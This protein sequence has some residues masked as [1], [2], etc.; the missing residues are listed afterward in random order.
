MS[1]VD[2][3]SDKFDQHSTTPSKP[4]FTMKGKNERELLEWLKNEVVIR[5]G[6]HA[7]FFRE[8]FK[9]LRAYKGS[10]HQKPGRQTDSNDTAPLNRF[11][12]KYWVNHVYELTENMVS[13]MTRVKPAVD[14]L[15]SNDEYADKVSAKC[16]DLL[17]RHLQY[18]NNTDLLLQKAHRH[19]LIF[20]ETYIATT[21]NPE[22]GDLHPEYVKMRD[23]A[24]L[25]VLK[26]KFNRN[27][28]VRIGDVSTK[29][30][31]PW[32]V[33]LECKG[34]YDKVKSV[35]VKELVHIE[36]LKRQYPSLQFQ[37]D[38]NATFFDINLL[39]DAPCGELTWQYTFYHVADNDFPEGVCIKFTANDVL[40]KDMLGFSHG[41]FPLL[42]LTDIDIP[43]RLHGMSRYQQV[44]VLQNAH[45]NLSQSIIK[46][47][48]LL[49]APKWMM[50][51]GTCKVD[52]LNNGRTVLQYQGPVAPQLVQMNPTSPTTLL[53]RDNITAEMGTIFGVHQVSRGEPPK[54]ITAAVAL[55]FLNEQETERSISDIAKH[56]ALVV[57]LAKMMISVA[58]DNYDVDDG[59]IL[60]VFGKTNKH[61]VSVFDTAHLHKDY[62]IRIQN[63]SALPQSK[64]ARM[65]RILTTMQYNAQLFTPERWAE[66]LEFGAVEKMHTLITE[67]INAAESE[68]EDILEGIEVEEPKEWEDQI[69][70]LR[71]HYKRMQ[72]RYFKEEV[73]PEVRSEFIEHVKITEM[74]AAEKASKNPLFASK[75][76]QLDN[77]PVFWNAPVPMSAEQSTAMV[78]GQANRGEAI[79][80]QIPA[81]EPTAV[82]GEQYGAPV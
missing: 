53:L 75:L 32:N 51:K 38:K 12:S 24:T 66:L 25:D 48:F 71:S 58:G 60:R 45:N 19:R 39:Q 40:D 7:P 73:P 52:Q 31:V 44:L 80:A 10:F 8:C 57:D 11:T 13:R 16:V 79:S 72:S 49:A 26:T 42:R 74:L 5:E 46:N 50:P 81:T 18:Q 65:E 56:N 63:S 78:E 33:L 64:S 6:F 14:V 28:P 21:W 82:P 62:D 15:P 1:N 36:E 37:V 59:R 34:E 41:S 54:G 4:F 22:L 27:M 29:I 17:L 20:G 2:F 9:N 47:E 30:E 69:L 55:Q 61:M 70:H 35:I 76:A 3:F 67:A 23:A 43:G 77:F 68:E